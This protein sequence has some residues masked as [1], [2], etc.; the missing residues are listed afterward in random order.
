MNHPFRLK[1]IENTDQAMI[2]QLKAITFIFRSGMQHNAVTGLYG[3]AWMGQVTEE[4]AKWWVFALSA[5]CECEQVLCM[6][7]CMYV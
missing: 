2:V 6:R 1:A 5:V 7:M 3:T 4:H